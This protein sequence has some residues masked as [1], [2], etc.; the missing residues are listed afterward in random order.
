MEQI[1]THAI[2]HS[3]V[4]FALESFFFF[5]FPDITVTRVQDQ[6]LH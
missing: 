6:I 2:I 1:G 5:F 3:M 4:L